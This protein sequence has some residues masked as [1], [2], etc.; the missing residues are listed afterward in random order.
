MTVA[1]DI[2]AARA[3]LEKAERAIDPE[4]KVHALDEALALLASCD[5]DEATDAERALIA[6]LRLSHT[7]RLLTQ[8]VTASAIS[9]DA[10]FDYTNLLFGELSS[11]VAQLVASNPQLR[12][13]YERFISLLGTEVAN[14][15]KPQSGAH[16]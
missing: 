8:L 10:W 12:E 15:L 16:P 13:N 6:N 4:V 2:A 1:R 11:E 9:M 14:I 7:R 3:L 5:A